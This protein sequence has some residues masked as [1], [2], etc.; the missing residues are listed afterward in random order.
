[1][2]QRINRLTYWTCSTAE[3]VVN[4][5]VAVGKPI[6]V[7]VVIKLDRPIKT[8]DGLLCSGLDYV[9][10]KVP[11]VKLPPKEVHTQHIILHKYPN[12]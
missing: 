2:H 8:I 6:A 3:N 10:N 1:M 9:E 4:K 7:P 12:T 11:S 5:A